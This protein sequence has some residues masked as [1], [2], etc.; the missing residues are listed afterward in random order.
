MTPVMQEHLILDDDSQRGDCVRAVIAS[1]LDLPLDAVPHFVQID[2]DGGP[3][4]WQHITSWLHA[5]GLALYAVDPTNPLFVPRAGEH[6]LVSGP[7]PR[8]Y[9][10]PGVC[11]ALHAVIYRD[12]QLAHDP[13]P[14][15]GGVVD[16]HERWAVRPLP[17]SLP[18]AS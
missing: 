17:D 12:E 7:S 8:G 1:L 13:Y 2:A 5:R 4:W 9:L 18:E 16:I 3:N 6:Y 14:D 15:G 11:Q 10:G